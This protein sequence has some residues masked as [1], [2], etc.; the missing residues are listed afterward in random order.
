[1]KLNAQPVVTPAY[2]DTAVSSGKNYIYSVSAID[3][4]ENES[5][6]SEEASET[7]P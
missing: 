5:G 4:R 3:L 1:V 7:M 6:R 2:R